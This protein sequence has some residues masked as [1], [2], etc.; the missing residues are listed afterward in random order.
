[1]STGI[2]DQLIRLIHSLSKA[3]KR[4]FKLYATRNATSATEMKF[5]QLFD[6]MD[7]T[8]DYSDK[9]ALKKLVEIKKTQ[10]SNI[11][12]HLYKQILTSLR[13]QHAQHIPTITIRESIDHAVILYHKGFYYQALKAL[14]KSKQLA[15]K[16]Q[17][18]MLQ[19]EIV[20]FEKLIESQYIT[21]SRSTRADELT[22]ESKSIE[23]H[24]HQSVEFSNLSL[25]L[26]ALYV[27]GGFVRDE[28]DF[29]YVHGFFNANLPK[30]RCLLY[31][32]DAADE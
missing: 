13:L 27:K 14:E 21:R 17:S 1:M 5:L 4:S 19:L 30:Y 26:Y 18:P 23:K 2:S 3:E 20:E 31:T 29:H 11:K 15:V 32:S 22:T 24:I 6:F 25:Q 8:P 28:K 16:F 10:L 9:A 12:A 7:K